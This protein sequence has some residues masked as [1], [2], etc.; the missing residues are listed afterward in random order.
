ME[1]EKNGCTIIIPTYFAGRMLQNCIESILDE[2][3][4]PKIYIHKNE[5][6]WLRACNEA[7]RDTQNDVILLND[8]TYVLTDIVR[9]MRE[10]AY[11]DD[12][13]GIVGGK[14]LSPN[15]DMIINYGIYVAVDGNTAHKHYGKERNSV[16]VEQQKAVEG[17]LMFIKRELIN[18][19]GDFDERYTMGYRAEIDLA[20]RAKEAG[21]KIMSTP[22]AEYVHFQHQTSGPLGITNDTFDVF[23]AQWGNKLKLGKV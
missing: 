2:V 13:I 5:I 17:S 14:A 23:N 16:K 22:K 6:G 8:D 10:L 15:Q 18:K 7:I 3:E 21:Y 4:S 9:E 11:S 12:T 1:K 19:I 20:F